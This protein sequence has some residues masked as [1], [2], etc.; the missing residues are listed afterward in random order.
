VI[1]SAQHLHEYFHELSELLISDDFFAVPF[2]SQGQ[3][4]RAYLV[5][6][7]SISPSPR[8]ILTFASHLNT[9]MSY[10]RLVITRFARTHADM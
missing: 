1:E 6:D 3:R 4:I 7:I 10:L 9:T 2:F 8:L 5:N